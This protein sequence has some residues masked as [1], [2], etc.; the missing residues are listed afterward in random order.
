MAKFTFIRN[1]DP[2]TCRMIYQETADFLNSRA[3]RGNEILL[4]EYTQPVIVY[5][6]F[7][8]CLIPV[9]TDDKGTSGK[10][11]PITP[12]EIIDIL[13]GLIELLPEDSNE[14]KDLE[15]CVRDYADGRYV[16]FR[17]LEWFPELKRIL[18]GIH[19]NP[20]FSDEAKETAGD[21]FKK[22]KHISHYTRALGTFQEPNLI[23]L[24]ISAI[25]SASHDL[26]LRLKS[27]RNYTNEETCYNIVHTDTLIHEMTHYMHYLLSE[28]AMRMTEQAVRSASSGTG[29]AS[30]KIP[31]LS[32]LK[33]DAGWDQYGN[34]KR[35]VVTESIARWYE[36]EH[37]TEEHFRLLLPNIL[38]DIGPAVK[39]YRKD[40][41]DSDCKYT[42]YQWPYSGANN[43]S[44]PQQ[45]YDV[46]IYS[47]LL[48]WSA[49]GWNQAFDV[50]EGKLPG[51]RHKSIFR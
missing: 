49:G 22:I 43:I 6:E 31:D 8:A 21:L 28:C 48:P 24:Y 50:I 16:W 13:R 26:F 4:P 5:D 39:Q 30:V 51:H 23:T 15:R 41:A 38:T 46:L 3:L 35:S 19:N 18:E 2:Q 11:D 14:R 42:L 45:W 10:D 1:T 36:L 40:I 9:F 37:L 27:S 25:E 33:R 32:Q 7:G 34:F 20:G 12:D 47:L 17:D 44:F 29:T